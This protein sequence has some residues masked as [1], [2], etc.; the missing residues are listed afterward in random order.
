MSISAKDWV[1]TPASTTVLR[2]CTDERWFSSIWTSWHFDL[3]SFNS[4]LAS[5][6]TWYSLDPRRRERLL[7]SFCFLASVDV[8]AL[9]LNCDCILLIRNSILVTACS[10]AFSSL[11]IIIDKTRRYNTSS[12]PIKTFNNMLLSA[13]SVETVYLKYCRKKVGKTYLF[14]WP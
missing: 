12:S 11:E 7:N 13:D 6:L 4:F 8:A 14:A 10:L 3:E 5:D 1:S 2:G 9:R